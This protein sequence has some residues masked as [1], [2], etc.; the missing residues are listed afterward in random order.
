MKAEAQREPEFQGS[1]GQ[2]S[3][4]EGPWLTDF[5]RDVFFAKNWL[6]NLIRRLT[7]K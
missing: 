1:K 4:E 6:R 2:I 7:I 5:H 3:G